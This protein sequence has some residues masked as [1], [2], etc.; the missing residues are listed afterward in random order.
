MKRTLWTVHLLLMGLLPTIAQKYQV[1]VS[2]AHEQMQTGQY[3]PTWESLETAPDARM[4]PRCEVRHLGPLGCTV[5]RGLWR[6]DG[7]R[8]VSRGW[9]TV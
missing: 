7:S 2:E 5:C 3:E 4:V 1:P 8:T 9:W 6:L